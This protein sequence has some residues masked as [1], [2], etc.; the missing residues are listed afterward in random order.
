MKSHRQK[1]ACLLGAALGLCT[2]VN[3]ASATL[4]KCNYSM[5]PWQ[6]SQEYTCPVLGFPTG[7]VYIHGSSMAGYD[8]GNAVLLA[9]LMSFSNPPPNSKPGTRAVGITS[10]GQVISTCDTGTDYST[11]QGATVADNN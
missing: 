5:W 2:W 8:R 7:T 4:I 11:A 6:N 9:D 3:Y 10:S 1:L